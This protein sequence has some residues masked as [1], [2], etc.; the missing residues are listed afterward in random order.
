MVFRVFLP[1]P[2]DNGHPRYNCHFSTVTL[3]R[4]TIYIGVSGFIAQSG[5]HWRKHKTPCFHSNSSGIV[6]LCRY[7][8]L[9]AQAMEGNNAD[10][11]CQLASVQ[12]DLAAGFAAHYSTLAEG[13]QP[14]SA[15]RSPS[16]EWATLQQWR[17]GPASSR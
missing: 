1:I 13:H 4:F 16:L 3:M 15:L 5:A 11:A 9:R 2:I 6:P 10:V 14:R 17:W 8:Q 12:A 7:I